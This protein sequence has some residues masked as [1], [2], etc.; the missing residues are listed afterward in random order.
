MTGSSSDNSDGGPGSRS[1]RLS[2]QL[3]TWNVTEVRRQP[4]AVLRAA[5][6]QEPMLIAF[7]GTPAGVLQD[8][9]TFDRMLS[10]LDELPDGFVPASN[11]SI[12]LSGLQL[13]HC[14]D[15]PRFVAVGSD[16]LAGV[17]TPVALWNQIAVAC[18]F[19]NS[20]E[21]RPILNASLARL[22]H[23]RS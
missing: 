4:R 13:L 11:A 17:I 23:Q 16:D 1:E 9:H 3:L 5:C 15:G 6:W 12:P 19:T 7:D 10:R 14:K 20:Q 8:V 18:G 22:G 2:D 21:L